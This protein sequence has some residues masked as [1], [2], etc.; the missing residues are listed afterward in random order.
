MEFKILAIH[1]R[2]MNDIA[3]RKGGNHAFSSAVTRARRMALQTGCDFYLFCQCERSSVRGS[4]RMLTA[5]CFCPLMG[6]IRQGE[7]SSLL[8]IQQMASGTTPPY[9]I[10]SRKLDRG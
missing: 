1:M 3:Q 9:L 5:S 6:L 10:E 2:R 4:L 8:I 7:L